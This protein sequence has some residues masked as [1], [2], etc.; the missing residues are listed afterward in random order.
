MLSEQSPV[1]VQ[2]G[3]KALTPWASP[4]D[5]RDVPIVTRAVGWYCP[6][7]ITYE[8]EGYPDGF[9][10]WLIDND[11]VTSNLIRDLRKS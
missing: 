9:R 10:Q 2:Q 11:L 1:R 7:H 4:Q 3:G 6:H 5:A 8:E